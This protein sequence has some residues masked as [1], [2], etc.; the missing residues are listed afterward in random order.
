M[1]PSKSNLEVFYVP[2]QNTAGSELSAA[3]LGFSALNTYSWTIHARLN[4]GFEK[5]E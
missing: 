1:R 4:Q 3:I 5:D 2:Q